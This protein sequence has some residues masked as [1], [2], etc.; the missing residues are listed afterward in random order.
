MNYWII[1]ENV[2]RGPMSLEELASTPGISLSTPVWRDDLPDWTTAGALPEVAAAIAHHQAPSQQPAYGQSPISYSQPQAPYGQQGYG[3][4]GYS[5]HPD[6]PGNM[7]PMPSTYLAWA[8]VVT[9]C[10]CIP[11]GIVAIFYAAKVA[12][13]YTRGD[14]EAAL[15]A[16]QRAELWIIIAFTLGIIF[17]PFQVIFQLMSAS[18]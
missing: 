14:Y 7:P 17:L 10:C 12:P 15:K 5:P 9:I 2:Q 6:G 3:P 13:A 8:I 16:S 18:V 11:F 1:S 4:N